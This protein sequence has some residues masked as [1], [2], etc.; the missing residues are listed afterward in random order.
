MNWIRKNGEYCLYAL[1]TAVTI[2]CGVSSDFMADGTIAANVVN[3]G[4]YVGLS[5]DMLLIMWGFP[6]MKES[7]SEMHKYVKQE[8]C[9][10]FNVDARD[11]EA[12]KLRKILREE[13]VG[14]LYF[15]CYGTNLY[16]QFIER[17]F[18]FNRENNCQYKI[19][20]VICN[21]NSKIISNRSAD[22]N[23]LLNQIS[24]CVREENKGYFSSLYLLDVPKTY[25]ACVLKR[26]RKAEW[27]SFQSYILS[28]K[29][30]LSTLNSRTPIISAGVE[31]GDILASLEEMLDKEW[32][33]I[34]RCDKPLKIIDAGEITPEGE[35][36]LN[37]QK[38]TI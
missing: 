30:F 31:N 10:H 2:L 11:E 21:P 24:E 19:N 20:L 27:V 36:F 32:E 7:I 28:D 12:E 25:R 22:R 5:M 1:V 23:L 9:V 14:E 3:T 6:K 26:N 29:R 37:E 33:D 17:V 34:I 8:E 4:F 15:F 16:G 35:A 38:A 18:D 13:S